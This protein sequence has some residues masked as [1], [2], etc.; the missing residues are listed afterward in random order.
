MGSA[1]EMRLEIAGEAGTVLR[2]RR[3]SSASYALRRGPPGDSA[4]PSG[5]PDG[6]GRGWGAFG[7]PLRAFPLERGRAVGAVLE[8]L[9]RKGKGW[10]LKFF[11]FFLFSVSLSLFWR[12]SGSGCWGV[13]DRC[14]SCRTNTLLIFGL[15]AYLGRLAARWG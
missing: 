10:Q 2:E 13:K 9:N 3:A 4:E 7:P 14:G 15:H 6:R 12:G 11:F 8:F 5:C 1:G